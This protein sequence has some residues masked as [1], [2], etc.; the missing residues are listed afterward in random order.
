MWFGPAAKSP[1]LTDAP[2]ARKSAVTLDERLREV[3][4]NL[5]TLLDEKDGRFLN[6][7]I[8]ERLN[9]LERKLD[10]VLELKAR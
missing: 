10:R 1:G 6:A 2:A 9:E 7:K 8:L 5:R 3:E 4:R